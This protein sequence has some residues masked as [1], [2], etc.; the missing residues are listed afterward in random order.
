[1]K[2]KEKRMRAGCWGARGI[3]FLLAAGMLIPLFRGVCISAKAVEAENQYV[4]MTE[5]SEVKLQLE[6]DY[7]NDS[8]KES[9][10]VKTENV[11]VLELT[12]HEVDDVERQNGVLLV[13]ENIIF[14]G[15]D[16]E[17][18]N[19]NDTFGTDFKDEYEMR[20]YLRNIRTHQNQAVDT[21]DQW[22]ID[23]VNANNREYSR[24]DDRVK[25]AVMDSG[26]TLSEDIDV[27]ERVNMV[28]DE[29]GVEPLF[30][31]MSG[32]GTAVAS[33]IAA[34]ENNFG[35]TGINPNAELY[36]IRV[37]DS[38]KQAPLSRIIQ[39]IYWCI[40]QNVDIINMSFGTEVRSGILEQVIKEA[41]NHGIL[42]IAAAGN[43]GREGM[44][45]VEFPAA[46]EEV[47]A[48]GSSNAQG[49]MCEASSAGT[50]IELLAPGEKIPAIGNFDEIVCTGGTSMAAPHVT[51]IASV[52]WAKDTTKSA[53][54][55]RALLDASANRVSVDGISGNG[56]VDLDYAL[57]VYDDFSGVYE[58]NGQSAV[59]PE[60]P[61]E[62]K[63]YEDTVV[64][65]CWSKSDHMN[66]LNGYT[67]TSA[68]VLAVIKQGAQTP[69]IYLKYNASADEE[70]RNDS[71]HGSYNYA[72][73]YIFMMRIARVCFNQGWSAAVAFAKVP[74]N[75]PIA[76]SVGQK[77]LIYGLSILEK[78]WDE[79]L[80]GHEI[81]D[82]NKARVLV[83]TAIH[84]IMDAY[85][86][87]AYEQKN[88]TWIH[89]A[90]DD[91][92]NK[93]YV[94]SRYKTAKQAALNI[95]DV[96]H[97][98]WTPDCLVLYRPESH[99]AAK[100]KMQKL[101]SYCMR[102]DQTQ[103]MEHPGWFAA[104]SVEN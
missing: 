4:V 45:T 52:L 32:H 60:N 25:V 29:E 101:A 77:Q 18:D 43:R 41:E 80:K 79:I 76:N 65:A 94:E 27:K 21:S 23:A 39:G 104:R 67:D 72:S 51:G 95:V 57:A 46:F 84:M 47:V 59:V 91:R 68:N 35:V 40:D 100:F 55:I 102:A 42:M 26:V 83:G 82:R 17:D 9:V 69:D 64:N 50:E 70:K 87:K 63:T 66:A 96:W 22:N 37:L 1:M 24:Q 10:T 73:N 103:Y 61:S 58:E 78:K 20:K 88:G 5:N 33:V 89:I 44:E 81:S 2:K 74:D 71:F 54:F 93:S 6:E 62:I 48:V 11:T 30:E 15:S 53:S 28:T 97:Y 8:Q 90:G 14:A 31:D 7:A 98:A 16:F 86:H 3:S 13:E 92:D 56:I 34:K 75:C 99:D 49:Q 36:S 19:F 12:A 85:A 38:N